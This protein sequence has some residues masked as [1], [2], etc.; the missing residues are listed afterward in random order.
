MTIRR[1]L[2]AGALAFG[3]L[4]GATVA[5]AAPAAA[6]TSIGSSYNGAS[7]VY[8][9]FYA[10]NNTFCIKKTAGTAYRAFVRFPGYV[11]LSTNVPNQWT[12]IRL[13][14]WGMKE[15][16]S[17]SFT[18]SMTWYSKKVYSSS[19]GHVRI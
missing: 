4:A 10:S 16:H 14:D 2:T 18:L 15:G 13:T 5:S 11:R 6:G 8:Y 1:K 7:H 19:S 12:C 3:V 17:A 9:K